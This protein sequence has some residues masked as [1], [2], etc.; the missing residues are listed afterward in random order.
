MKQCSRYGEYG[1]YACWKQCGLV[2][3]CKAATSLRKKMESDQK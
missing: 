2:E 3:S 1:N